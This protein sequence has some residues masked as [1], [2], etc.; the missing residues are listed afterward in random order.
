[1]LPNIPRITLHSIWGTL[2][3]AQICYKGDAFSIIEA[4]VCHWITPQRWLDKAVQ[5]QKKINVDHYLRDIED[6]DGST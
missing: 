4:V 6:D 5:K 1:V 2:L 3:Y